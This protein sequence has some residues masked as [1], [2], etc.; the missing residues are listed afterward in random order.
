MAR[1]AIATARIGCPTRSIRRPIPQMRAT[2]PGNMQLRRLA[3]LPLAYTLFATEPN[4]ATR[5]WWGHVQALANDSLAGR[6]T[7]SEGYKK[8]AAYVV[9]QFQRAGLKPPGESGWDPNG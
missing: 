3:L 1:S 5:R 9:E 2:I 7:G 4:D 6:D 8:A